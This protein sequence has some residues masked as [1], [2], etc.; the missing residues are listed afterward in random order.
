VCFTLRIC[1]KIWMKSGEGGLWG[2]KLERKFEWKVE[3]ENFEC[4][5][6]MFDKTILIVYIYS[7]LFSLMQ[8]MGREMFISHLHQHN[9]ILDYVW[10]L[11]NIKNRVI[12]YNIISE[13]VFQNHFKKCFPKQFWIMCSEIFDIFGIWMEKIKSKNYN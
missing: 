1:L 13:N 10:I 12:T 4:T 8:K 3:R 11:I 7:K 9:Y 5:R 6:Y 2:R